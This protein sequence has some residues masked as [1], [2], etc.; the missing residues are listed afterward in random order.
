MESP[1]QYQPQGLED[2]WYQRWTEAGCFASQP[3]DRPAYTV[4]IP[5]P[6]VTGV[7]H[8]GHMLNNTIQDMLIR[9][10]RMEGYNACW[11]PGTDHASIAT[12]TKVV[13]M[14]QEQGIHKADLTR[15]EFLK[16]AWAWKE[17]YGGII[18]SQLRKLGASLDWDRE[19]FTMD[20]GLSRAVVDAFVNL[21]RDGL[22]YRGVRMVNWDPA[23][24]TALADDEVIFK[25][26]QGQLVH[27]RYRIRNSDE[28]VTIATVRPET[29]MADTALCVHPEDERYR[30]LVGQSAVIPLIGKAI[31]VIADPYVDM[32]FG[33][34]C[35]KVT[36]AHD[37]ND[38]ALGLKHNLEVIDM[39]DEQ[40]RLNDKAGIMVGLDRFEARRQILPM[41]QAEGALVRCE[42]YTSSVGHSERTHAVVEPRLSLQW[43]VKMQ[44][45]A[46]PAL[47]AV[48]GGDVRLF[49]D[50]FM[51]TYRHWMEN[52]RD[53]CISRQL[54]WGHRIPAWYS[55]DGRTWV[56]EDVETAAQL[57][58][59]QWTAGDLRQDEDVLDTWFSSWLWPLSVFDPDFIRQHNLG[60]KPNRD[61]GYYYPTSV[62]VTGPDILFFWVA[63][64]IMAGQRFHGQ[65]P[66]RDVYL[67]GIVRDQQG[68][69]MSK[70]LGNSPDPLDLIA[71]YGADSLRMGLLFSSPAGNDLL[72]DESQLEQGRHFANKLWNAHRL[73]LT[74]H[75]Q[76]PSKEE[77]GAE[78]AQAIRWFSQRLAATG[79]ELEQ[80]YAQYKLSEVIRLI[81]KLIWDD[82]CSW[83]LEMVKP[84]PGQVMAWSVLQQSAEF[85]RDLLALLHPVMPFVTEELFERIQ[86]LRD[87]QRQAL[88]REFLC[89]STYPQPGQADQDYLTQATLALDLVVALRHFKGQNK[90]GARH[91]M[92]LYPESGL[93]FLQSFEPI[94]NRLT[95]VTL[96]YEN[97]AHGGQE[98]LSALMCG[99]RKVM[100]DPGVELNTGQAVEQ[101]RKDL[102]Y[103][104]KFLQSVRNKLHNTSFSSK[105]PP[106]VLALEQKKE[107]D[108]L[109]KI[110]ALQEEL[111]R[112]MP[113]IG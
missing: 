1:K 104:E 113:D 15:D 82:Y 7:L 56:A 54:W 87:P 89:L 25:E 61:L 72:F 18:L 49:P 47:Q 85:L 91:P 4:V 38:Y 112:L 52:C 68:R 53:W 33:T 14:L 5:P 30:H 10:A 19:A 75:E 46:E 69:K 106:Q 17:K 92:T 2:R 37:P 34:G 77:S 55:P 111:R 29:I 95:A 35:L 81:Y 23:G 76:G 108:A 63:R 74:W 86:P 102:E 8:L 42:P 9:K 67:T 101:I 48:T 6:N 93:E 59:G 43:F 90:L 24:Q 41:L 3:D 27:I 107:Q 58:N 98:K 11:V 62:L 83:Y 65:I 64:M 103:Q 70:S 80:A 84:L 66:F 20:P 28:Y 32:E 73:L 12:E 40:G 78:Q 16:H 97:P 22:V 96:D 26:V 79:V 50:K 44:D 110:R 39:L 94:L 21:Y 109:D 36:P 57:S 60:Q 31:P 71:Q 45:M 51:A 100:V 88:D 13:Q 99:T 105:A